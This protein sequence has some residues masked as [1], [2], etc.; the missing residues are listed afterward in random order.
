MIPPTLYWIAVAI[1]TLRV[2]TWA[3]ALYLRTKRFVVRSI[4]R[5][6]SVFGSRPQEPTVE[7]TKPL[8]VRPRRQRTHY[9]ESDPDTFD[10]M[11]NGKL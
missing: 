8:P 1:V 4:D 6:Q 7:E 10:R 2:L 9:L 3:I 11:I 5:I